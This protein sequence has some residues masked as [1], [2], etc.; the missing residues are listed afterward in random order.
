M[1]GEFNDSHTGNKYTDQNDFGVSLNSSGKVFLN[2]ASQGEEYHAQ[3]D[4]NDTGTSSKASVAAAVKQTEEARNK[5]VTAVVAV[6]GAVI[7]GAVSLDEIFVTPPEFDCGLEVF[8]N[9]IY[10]TVG[11]DPEEYTPKDGMVIVLKN[12]FTNRE[13]PMTESFVQGYFDDLQTNMTYS[14][15][16]MDGNTVLYSETV[17]T[18]SDKEFYTLSDEQVNFGSFEAYDTYLSGYMEITDLTPNGELSVQ[19]AGENQT[20]TKKVRI[21]TYDEE[22]FEEKPY[23]EDEPIGDEE[24]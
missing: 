8:T 4:C 9:A 15:R 21:Y 16:I 1:K 20:F 18:K 7:V 5:V 2:P 24:S 23:T 17:K 19:V 3:R 13:E 22:G 14:F 11:Y 10:Y 6:A 12:D